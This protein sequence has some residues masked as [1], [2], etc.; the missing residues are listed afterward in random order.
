MEIPPANLTVLDGKDATIFC[1]AIGAPTPNISWV[2]NGRNIYK[3]I[4]LFM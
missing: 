1:R 4:N 3:L 2:Y